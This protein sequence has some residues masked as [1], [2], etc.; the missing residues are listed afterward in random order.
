MLKSLDE[1]DAKRSEKGLSVLALCKIAGVSPVTY[2]RWK[3]DRTGA[4]K[5]RTIQRL[6]AAL[7]GKAWPARR[8]PPPLIRQHFAIVH[9][10]CAKTLGLIEAESVMVDPHANRPR[11]PGWLSHMRA[12]RLA[13]YMVVTMGNIRG[14]E[15]AKAIGVSKQAI[16]KTLRAVEDCRDD[17]AFDELINRIEQ[18][19]EVEEAAA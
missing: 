16:S 4:P 1:I 3:T 8:M 18:L 6:A 10:Y 7:D 5:L 19:M 13:I 14:T 2:W 9:A 12:R 11:D 15:L 17:P